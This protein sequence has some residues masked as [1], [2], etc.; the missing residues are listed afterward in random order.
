MVKVVAAHLRQ[1]EKGSFVLFEI[2][3]QIE[4]LQ[5]QKTGRFYATARRCMISTTFDATTANNFVGQSL[6][7]SIDRVE[8][9]PYDYKIPETG[10][11]VVLAHRWDYVP[12]EQPLKSTSRMSDPVQ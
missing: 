8:C 12:E 5:S 4:L 7:G 10:E 9:D 2:M 11:E 1:S 6:P 3:G